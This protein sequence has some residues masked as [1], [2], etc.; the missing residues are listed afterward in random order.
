MS[1]RG[2]F[3]FRFERIQYPALYI[4]RSK[5]GRS[6]VTAVLRKTISQKRIPTRPGN[7]LIFKGLLHRSYGRISGYVPE[8]AC[9]TLKNKTIGNKAYRYRLEKISVTG[10]LSPAC[11]GFPV[12]PVF[13]R[14]HL[15]FTLPVV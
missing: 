15:I 5:G 4:T 12:L 1:G 11:W 3:F 13:S 9:Q 2:S 10:F 7:G 8:R 6:Q 14:R